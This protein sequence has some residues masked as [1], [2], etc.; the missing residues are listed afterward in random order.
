MKRPM[1][2]V[3]RY[4]GEDGESVIEDESDRGTVTPEQ[5]QAGLDSNSFGDAFKSARAAGDSTFTWKGKSYGTKLASEVK[6]AAK[7]APKTETSAPKAESKP[8]PKADKEDT[9]MSAEAY[10]RAV[11]P[12]ESNFPTQKEAKA[13]P[14]GKAKA[15]K[16]TT[17]SPNR[18]YKAGGSVS[19]RADGCAQR[20]KTKGKM[21]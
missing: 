3:K 21:C 4:S 10:R 2:K 11:E 13:G 20:G 15:Q 18:S 17:K 16:T 7:P 9:K 8:A 5:K 14:S 6:P 1:K 12:F 19:S